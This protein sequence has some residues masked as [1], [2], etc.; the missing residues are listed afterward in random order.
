M[1]LLA[2]GSLSAICETTT[3]CVKSARKLHR[4]A[5][6]PGSNQNGRAGLFTINQKITA[7][8]TKAG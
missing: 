7:M 2:P 3:L 1:F 6:R 5:H 4:P 8:A